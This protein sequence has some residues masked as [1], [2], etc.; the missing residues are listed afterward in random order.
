MILLLSINIDYFM[1]LFSFR[2]I[3]FFMVLL[4]LLVM[5]FLLNVSLVLLAILIFLVDQLLFLFTV[6]SIEVFGK[7]G[8]LLGG[9]EIG[10]SGCG[11]G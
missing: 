11:C 8:L 5:S 2:M 10:F 7:T 1:V 6:A 9:V 4:L 3:I